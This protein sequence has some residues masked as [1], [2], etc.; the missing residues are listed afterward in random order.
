MSFH[1]D[2]STMAGMA[3]F[4]SVSQPGPSMPKIANIPFMAP[5]CGDK[6]LFQIREAAT[7]EVRTG[8]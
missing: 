8:I 6:R 5:Y 7:H 2:T 3:H 1:T 4:S